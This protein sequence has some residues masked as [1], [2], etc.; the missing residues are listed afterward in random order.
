MT[1]AAWLHD[2]DPFIFRVTDTLGP[3]W[4]GMSYLL[5]FFVAW[6]LIRRVARAGIS[7]L[8]THHASDFVLAVAVGVVVGGRLGYVFLYSPDLL[9]TWLDGPPWWGAIA[10][11]DGGMASHG[12]IVGGLLACLFYAWRKHHSPLHLLDL[13]AFGAP[14]GLCFGR[15][16]NFINGELFG[17][18]ASPNL[19]WAVKFPQELFDWTPDRWQNAVE[20][21]PD[22]ARG[23]ARSLYTTVNELPAEVPRIIASVQA[24]HPEIS[25]YVAEILP[26]RHPSQIYAAFAEGLFVFAVLAFAWRKPQKPGVI[27][28]LFGIA[29]AVGRIIDEFFRR[30]DLHIMDQE[31]AALGV[32]RGQWLSALVLLAGLLVTWLALRRPAPRM[33]AW[34]QAPGA[35]S[36]DTEPGKK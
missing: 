29:Y 9:V 35:P 22:A 25:R 32:T 33:G 18:I 26:A 21:H 36:P 15:I 14:L 16:A 31:F 30:P 27:A 4:Y 17:R 20:Q 13:F 1:L 24:D 8:T 11:N 2:I 7:T 12:G 19:P 5:G 6:L 34:R 3:R 28:G 10:I 23:L